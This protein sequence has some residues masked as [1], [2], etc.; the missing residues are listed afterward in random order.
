MA[1]W[2]DSIHRGVIDDAWARQTCQRRRIVIGLATAA[3][4]ALSAFALLAGGGGPHRTGLA[5]S[6]HTSGPARPITTPGTSAMTRAVLND[7]GAGNDPLRG[8]YT[9]PGLKAALILVE[10]TRARYSTCADAI[11]GAIHNHG[12]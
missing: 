12:G 4:V 6:G 7:C 3:V 1:S 9:V 10:T 11:S 8:H 5:S 2:T